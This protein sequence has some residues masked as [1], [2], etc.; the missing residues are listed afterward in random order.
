MRDQRRPMR[1]IQRAELIDVDMHG[2]ELDV[3]SFRWVMEHTK[4]E[5]VYRRGDSNRWVR[6]KYGT[7]RGR[8]LTVRSTAV[9]YTVRLSALDAQELYLNYGAR[10]GSS[11]QTTPS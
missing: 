3:N 6:L 10:N 11:W 9:A 4:G 2:D 7:V 8:I 1:L 5:Q